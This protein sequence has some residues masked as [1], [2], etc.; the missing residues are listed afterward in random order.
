MPSCYGWPTAHPQDGL[1][2]ESGVRLPRDRNAYADAVL[3]TILRCAGRRAVFL[4]TFE[5]DLCLLLHRKQAMFPGEHNTAQR[6][7]L[8]TPPLSLHPPSLS[9][10]AIALL[11]TLHTPLPDAQ[12]AS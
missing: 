6:S 12:S 3:S 5:P 1:G 8:F 11:L 10:L 7:T 4:T 2:H 9:A